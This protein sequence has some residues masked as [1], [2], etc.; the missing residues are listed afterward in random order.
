VER[1]DTIMDICVLFG[2]AVVMITMFF[3]RGVSSTHGQA[4]LLTALRGC[5]YEFNASDLEC[6]M[7]TLRMFLEEQEDIPWP[8]LEYVI[9]QINYG[10]RV[11]DDLDRRCLMSVLRQFMTPQVLGKR[12]TFTPSGNYRI[13]PAASLDE[14]R[15]YIQD[16]PVVEAPEVFGMHL[17]AN[18]SFQLQETRKVMD[19]IL[20]IQPRMAGGV[21]GRSSDEVVAD[22]A[23][24]LLAGLPP[25]LLQEHAAAGLFDRT[26]TGQ[27]NSLSVVLGQ[28]M[29]RFNRLTSRIQATLVEVQKAIKGLVVM[30]DELERMFQALLSNQV[31]ELWAKVAYPSLK[32]L[33]SWVKDYQRRIHSM[34]QWLTTG[35]PVCF[36]LPGFFFPQVRAW[37]PRHLSVSCLCGW[38]ASRLHQP[39][40]STPCLGLLVRCDN[41]WLQVH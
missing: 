36:W 14:Y 31:P 35:L 41:G 15:A 38:H 19:T 34:M 22:L 1:F 9:G 18:I 5:R 11:T 29:F 40:I 21:A 32:P 3:N 39:Y 10:G 17:N 6:S 13:P 23:E 26:A 7:M 28:E 30:S 16:L 33:G 24:A 12:Y 4:A 20:S 2:A 8:A 27:L 37:L 25:L